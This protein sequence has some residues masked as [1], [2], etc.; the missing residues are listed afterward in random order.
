MLP[1]VLYKS[2]RN[3]DHEDRPR[4]NGYPR[5]FPRRPRDPT[6]RYRGDA[7]SRTGQPDIEVIEKAATRAKAVDLAQVL[8][9]D[10]MIT[11]L[12][13]SVMDGFDAMSRIR[14]ENAGTRVLV[15]PRTGTD[16]DLVGAIEVAAAG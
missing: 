6:P 11:D 12:K 2:I 14:D 1:D 4:A 10:G 13:M 5:S 8:G 3:A 16:T 15:L 7:R 9:P